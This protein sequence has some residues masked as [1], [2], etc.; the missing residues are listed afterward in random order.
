METKKCPHCKANIPFLANICQYC[1]AEIDLKSTQIS[2][3]QLIENIKTNIDAIDELK[4]IKILGLIIRSASIV[5]GISFLVAIIYSYLFDSIMATIFMFI[6]PFF[7]G[8]SLFISIVDKFVEG[9]S[10]VHIKHKIENISLTV[11]K[12]E[13]L[14]KIY[15]AQSN[16]IKSLIKVFN[17]RVKNIN[18]KIKDNKKAS[19]LI[20]IAIFFFMNNYILL[21]LRPNRNI[22]KIKNQ[23]FQPQSTLFKGVYNE[24]FRIGNSNYII[25]K[26]IIEGKETYKLKLDVNLRIS[27][28]NQIEKIRIDTFKLFFVDNNKIKITDIPTFK[29]SEN[30]IQF[31]NTESKT[32]QFSHNCNSEQEMNELSEKIN[33]NTNILLETFN[34]TD[35]SSSSFKAIIDEKYNWHVINNYEGYKFIIEKDTENTGNYY[36]TIELKLESRKENDKFRFKKLELYFIPKSADIFEVSEK[37]ENAPV[38]YTSKKDFTFK[39]NNRLNFEGDV[40]T[41]QF[42]T[43]SIDE[44][45]K[46]ELIELTSTYSSRLQIVN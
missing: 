35:M 22:A 26:E 38:F 36:A 44:T 46:N 39:D 8:I 40:I 1:G 17:Q 29:S 15:Y 45:T 24:D 7:G 6:F 27:E 14:T 4:P 25:N 2:E 16:E 41:V 11:N 31:N 10:T 43:K 5:F 20:S 19:I 42:K 13:K 9:K 32:I 28:S 30:G 12:N 34:K 33:Q 23:T 37:L 21:E 18:K 3:Q